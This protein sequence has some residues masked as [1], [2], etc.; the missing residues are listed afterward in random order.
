MSTVQPP[1]TGYYRA[2]LRSYQSTAN[3][4]LAGTVHAFATP[5]EKGTNSQDRLW[6]AW[7]EMIRQASIRAPEDQT[8]LVDLVVALRD[9]GIKPDASNPHIIWGQVLWTG[10]P[11]LNAQMR[12]AWNWAA[13]P[14]TSDYTWRNV[15]GFA[16][17]LTLAGIDFSLLGLWTIRASLEEKEKVSATELMAAAEWF[18]Y[19]TKPIMQWSQDERQFEGPDDPASAPGKLLMEEGFTRSGFS[20]GRLAFWQRRIRQGSTQR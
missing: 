8:R 1:L 11:L 6:T 3:P 17:R 9:R 12:E 4:D 2:L 20:S 15:N 14:S 7:G 5:V 18:K 19:L 16:A 10:L 13:P